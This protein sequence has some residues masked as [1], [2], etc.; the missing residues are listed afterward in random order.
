MN[1]VVIYQSHYGRTKQYAEWIAEELGADSIERREA[2][3][4]M[5]AGY[6]CAVYGGGLYAGGILGV[7][8]VAKNP[9]KNLVVFTV[10]LA[11]PAVTDYSEIMDRGFPDG[12]GKPLRVFH[13]RGGIDYKELSLI[14]KG[15]MG[16]VKKSAE[17]KPGAERSDEDK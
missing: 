6:D 14:H 4:T 17:K 5:L 16:M 3:A 1:T 11:D 10:G 2:S 13:L 12:A 15:M 9:V 7:S 8:F